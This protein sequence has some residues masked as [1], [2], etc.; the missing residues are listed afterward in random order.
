LLIPPFASP[1]ADYA[2]AAAVVADPLQVASCIAYSNDPFADSFTASFDGATLAVAATFPSDTSSFGDVWVSIAAKAGATLALIFTDAENGAMRIYS[3][4]GTEIEILGPSPSPIVSASLPAD[5]EYY[6]AIALSSPPMTTQ[7]S[8]CSFTLTSSDFLW[9][10]PVI[11]LWDD[12][13]TT[14]Q[15]WACP[16]LLLPPLTE[17]T[18]DWYVDCAAADGVLISDDVNGC[19]GFF[20]GSHATT[21]TFSFGASGT[22]SL[23]LTET[24]SGV[25]PNNW[26]AL[27]AWGGFNGVSGDSISIAYT[28]TGTGGTGKSGSAWL[29]DDTGALI[30]T[31]SS[32]TGTLTFSAP[33]AYT[34]RYTIRVQVSF[35]VLFL[36]GNITAAATISSSG[37]L[38]VNPIQA[39]YDLSLTC[40]GNLDCGSSCP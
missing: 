10:N 25:L 16:K 3:C 4:D 14:R 13:G 19:I 33:L 12:S 29:Y 6:I 40:S 26:V 21:D 30:E 36:G 27:N 1:Y 8:S 38:T 2:T 18:G 32:T 11:A 31:I 37:T 5:G 9:V 22:S 20:D 28:A 7:F 17:S 39:R 34:G 23:T 24:S 35:E 15:L